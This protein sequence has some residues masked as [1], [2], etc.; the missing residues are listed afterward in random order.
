MKNK[1]LLASSNLLELT[2]HDDAQYRGS[3]SDQRS[4]VWRHG[5][6]PVTR[7]DHR[8]MKNTLATSLL[9]AV[10]SHAADPLSVGGIYP[11][12]G[13]RSAVAFPTAFV[14]TLEDSSHRVLFS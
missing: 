2:N 6:K 9:L 11:H 4:V 12:L 7:L 14:V 3:D 5:K 8:P 1:N 10:C 13:R